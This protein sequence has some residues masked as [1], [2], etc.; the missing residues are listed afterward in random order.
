MVQLCNYKELK[1]FEPNAGCHAW[2]CFSADEKILM[3]GFSTGKIE[4]WLLANGDSSSN[5]SLIA[6]VI[7]EDMKRGSVFMTVQV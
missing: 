4:L 7:P 2:S 6:T 3:L 5:C 1:A